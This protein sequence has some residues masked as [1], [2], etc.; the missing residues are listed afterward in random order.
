MR[1]NRRELVYKKRKH[2]RDAGEMGRVWKS[3]VVG[4]E[5]MEDSQQRRVSL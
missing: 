1:V 3:N 5:L 2:R 4:R